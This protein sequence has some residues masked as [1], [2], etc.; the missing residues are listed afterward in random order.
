MVSEPTPEFGNCIDRIVK[1]VSCDEYVGIQQIQHA[2]QLDW[3]EIARLEKAE[4]QRAVL[5]ARAEKARIELEKRWSEN[6]WSRIPSTHRPD[7]KL[8]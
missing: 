7:P 3:L 1:G 2:V 5:A 8:M 6:P 4:K